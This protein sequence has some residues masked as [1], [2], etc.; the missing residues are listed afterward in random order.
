MLV[1]PSEIDLSGATRRYLSG[2]PAAQRRERGT[3]W[4][5]LPPARQ[6]LLVLAQVRCGHTHA[7][8]AAGFGVGTATVYWYIGEAVEVLVALAP[9]LAAAARGAERKAFVI[10]G[11]TLRPIDRIA[12][13]RPYY[14][15]CEDDG[16]VVPAVA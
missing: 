1:Y 9:D 15:G 3:R 11:G 5:R 8:L 13:D 12:D 2:L 16:R 6:A 7:Q 14:S 10:L 4:R